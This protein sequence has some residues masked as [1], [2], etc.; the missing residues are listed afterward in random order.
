MPG[1]DVFRSDQF[2]LRALTAAIQKAP[3][4]PR[5]IA[6]LGLFEEM[7]ISETKISI[8]QRDGQLS[9]IQSTPRGAPASTLGD[10]KRTAF[11][12]DIRQLAREATIMA[13]EVQNVRAFGSDNESEGIQAKVNLKLS[14]LRAMHEVTLER[15]RMG[16]IKGIILDADGTTTIYNLFTEFGVVQQTATLTPNDASDGGDA[17]RA[18]IV[19]AQRLVEAELGNEPISGYRA[20][21]GKDF[22]DDIRADLGVVQT[23]R[24]AD[25]QALL[26]QQA[27]ARS[28]M[29]GGVVWE[30]YRGATGGTAFV[31]DSEAYLLPEGTDIFKTYFAP[32]DFVET[33]N[34]IGLPL[35]A[36]QRMM[37]F[38]RGVIIHSQSNP[39][40]IC[41]RPR[42]VVKLTIGT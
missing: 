14:E 34:T 8:E 16:A 9:L 5:R 37:D 39:L 6:E 18:E 32:A 21:C 40:A 11:A 25:P 28:F 10:A 13:D 42:A 26:Q 29:Y 15:L 38:D 36:K 2:S 24:Y 27:N 22:F 12:F 4:K 20:F 30:E 7:G 17:L 1:L 41:T 23:L 19:A 31:P 33:V 35:Y 3:Y